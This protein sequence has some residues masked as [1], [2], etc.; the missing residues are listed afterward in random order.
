ML[1]ERES[2]E[3]LA[4]FNIPVNQTRLATT[5]DEAVAHA[6]TLGYPVVLKI[7]S[8][9]VIYKSDVGGVELNIT[10][11]A[12][13]RE[14]FANIL[15][16]T[17]QALPNALVHGVSVQPM[18][19]RRHARELMIGVVHDNS[20]GPVI[21][22]GAGGI[23]TE[24]QHDRS[25]A[26]PPLNSYLAEKMIARTR[27]SKTLGEFKHM[28]AVDM[29]Q[30]KTLM[31]RVSDMVCE[32]PDLLEADINPLLIDDR[33]A[34]V[35]DARIIVRKTR[36]SR[37]YRHMAIM[38]YPSDMVEHMTLND[39]T[40]VTI[41]PM[42]TEDADMQ[43]EFVRNLSEESRYNRYMSS[44]KQLSQPVLVR[45]TQ[46]DFDREMA[47]VMTRMVD[48]REEQLGVSR[49]FT[50]PD[51]ESCEFALVVA[52]NWQGRGIGPIMMNRLF[53]AA[54]RQG[55]TIMRGEVLA[56]NKGMLKLMAKLG[57]T[58]SPHP[59]DRQLTW[60]TRPL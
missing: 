52:D 9:D 58:V 17:R 6:E 3:I 16:R 2:K 1:S 43:Q 24:I 27:I 19:R 28:P 56:N 15:E 38:P 12:S 18:V 13:V 11:S 44:I 41:R 21:T 31:G 37:R 55:L 29:D 25:I 51:N 34:V 22:F 54:K 57:F 10:N 39:N 4:A 35:L 47:L 23:A 20:F 60:V 59:E 42:R 53:D 32:L 5:A 45:F 40:E 30:L 46:L 8:P 7:D 49:Y 33:N 26:L 48:G 50:D 14:V 36:H